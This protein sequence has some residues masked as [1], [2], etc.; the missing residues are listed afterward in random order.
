[1]G[2][3][4]MSDILSDWVDAQD[5]VSAHYVSQPLRLQGSRPGWPRMHQLFR[6]MCWVYNHPI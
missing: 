3:R 2:P 1:M 4:H 5:D 6:V